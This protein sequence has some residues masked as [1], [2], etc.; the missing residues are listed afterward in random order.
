MK[1]QRLQMVDEIKRALEI[2]EIIPFRYLIQHIGR[3]RRGVRHAQVRR[4]LH[5]ARRAEPVRPRSAAWRFC[6]RTFPTSFPAPSV[7]CTFEEL[8]HLG[9]NFVFDTGHANMGEGVEAEFDLMKERIR[10]THVHDNNGK[11]DIH[12]FPLVAEGGTI[13]WKKTM[14]LLRSRGRTSIRWC[15]N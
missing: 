13:D 3:R 7:C 14:E 2:A 11:D 8:T 1:A 10:S 9:L 6:W 4:R 15:W 5:R 12:L